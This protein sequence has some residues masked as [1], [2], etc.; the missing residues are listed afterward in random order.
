MKVH[1]QAEP[2]GPSEKVMQGLSGQPAAELAAWRVTAVRHLLLPTLQY[3]SHC[4]MFP[5]AVVFPAHQNRSSIQ[6]RVIAYC[7]QYFH[8]CLTVPSL[9]IIRAVHQSTEA[10]LM[11]GLQCDFMF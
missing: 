9:K 3:Y 1:S 11:Q 6:T 4:T 8:S 7:K 5:G 2:G 10:A